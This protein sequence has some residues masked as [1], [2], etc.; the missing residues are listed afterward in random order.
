MEAIL[1]GEERRE[2]L[3]HEIKFVTNASGVF[4][5][6][7]QEVFEKWGEA[8]V[9]PCANPVTAPCTCGSVSGSRSPQRRSHPSPP[10]PPP[11]LPQVC[12]GTAPPLHRPALCY[13]IEDTPP[14]V[15]AKPRAGMH[16]KGGK[17]PP[18][19]GA[20]PMPSHCP[21]DGKC[22]PQWHL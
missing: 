16:W 19:Q 1:V 20:R 18:L 14:A 8:M 17:P 13:S 4:F 5:E 3:E 22:Q 15:R 11:E 9:C 21:P 7:V 12:P 6:D 2:Q 10:P